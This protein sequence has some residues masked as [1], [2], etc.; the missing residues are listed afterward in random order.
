MI[1]IGKHYY[2]NLWA[3]IEVVIFR[4]PNASV[5][6]PKGWKPEPINP[7]GEGDLEC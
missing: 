6:K 5:P 3:L 2:K 1:K 4:K 7:K